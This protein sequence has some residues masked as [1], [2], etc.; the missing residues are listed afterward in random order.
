MKF[1]C[2]RTAIGVILSMMLAFTGT[3]P[4][5]AKDKATIVE[6]ELSDAF[7][8]ALG[9]EG[10]KTYNTDKSEEYLRQIA[11]SARFAVETNL[12]IL[13]QQERMLELLEAIQK[14]GD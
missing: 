10:I 5:A 14:K 8:K 3:G 2:N 9:D 12:K 4:V 11:V 7:Y 6:V 13:K 1:Q